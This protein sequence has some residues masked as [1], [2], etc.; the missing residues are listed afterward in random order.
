[1]NRLSIVKIFSAV[2]LAMMFFSCSFRLKSKSI[3]V[4]ASFDEIDQ[5]I[6]LGQ[7]ADAMKLLEKLAKRYADP[8]TAIS[9]YKRYALMGETKLCEKL[10]SKANKKNPDSMELTA[11]YCHLLTGIEKI[12]EAL[13]V[14]KKL[15]GT[16]YGSIYAEA[17]LRSVYS[18]K[19]SKN[20]D[21]YCSQEFINV[22][23]DAYNGSYD[24]AWLRNAAVA[25]L[26]DGEYLN[27]A[28]LH[29]DI[30]KSPSDAYF[31]ACVMFDSA[32]YGKAASDLEWIREKRQ[33]SDEYDFEEADI[34]EALQH[35]AQIKDK[36]TVA[37]IKI[38]SLLSDS[39]VCLGEDDAAEHIR[40]DLIAS[41]MLEAVQDP[42]TDSLLPAVY[43]NSALFSMVK[44]DL[45][46]AYNTLTFLVNKWPDFV[47]GLIA[48][49]NYAYN[50]AMRQMN[51]PLTNSVRE[52]GVRSLDM[53]LFDEV[54]KIPIADVLF[55]MEESLKR[56]DS[57]VLYVAKLNLEDKI[58]KE[59]DERVRLAKIW[60]VLERNT[61]STDLYPP[62]ITRY[63]VYG[64]LSLGKVDEAK[65]LFER[66]VASR[67]S[68][69][70][71]EP[72]ET[73]CALKMHSMQLWEIEYQAWFAAYAANGQLARRLYEYS[74]YESD[75]L[76]QGNGTEI[77][78]LAAI[79]S[80][81]N[82][83]MIY[84]SIGMKDK[85]AELYGRAGGRATDSFEKSEIMYRLACVYMAKKEKDAA[86]KAL[87]YCLFLNPGNYRGRMMLNK[88]RY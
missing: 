6:L 59:T 52:A 18:E 54:P 87:E 55:K 83:A 67:Y 16:K 63:A 62:E 10:L 80:A 53:K 39:Y 57:D 7:T 61:V 58:S 1:M 86:V 13:K 33:K 45:S 69:N 5:C 42:D 74:V 51:D 32:K 40:N 60:R 12:P 14:G 66:Y 75:S 84:S 31:W 43:L 21:Y 29:P 44:D 81:A 38:I 85:A 68:F 22:F 8:A 28:S 47:P 48:Y 49:G 65:K 82:L 23:V 19:E 76:Y 70:E 17:F 77:S 79:S 72:F 27:A 34:Y 50:T 35:A 26:K 15:V 25:Y 24:N 71:K 9:V 11:L 37:E 4:S 20:F 88:I 30:L 73:E 56:H 78:P 36:K 46:A 64:L 41:L 3:Q 2:I